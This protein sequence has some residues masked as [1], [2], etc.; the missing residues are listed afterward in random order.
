MRRAIVGLLILLGIIPSLHSQDG[1]FPLCSAEELQHV[2]ALQPELDRLI[3]LLLVE[4]GEVIDVVVGYSTSQIAARS[5]FWARLSPCAEAIETVDLLSN[6]SGDIAAMAALIHA[7]VDSAENPYVV[8]QAGGVKLHDRVLAHFASIAALIE[9]GER[10]AAPAPGER[11][12]PACDGAALEV[13]LDA[14]RDS[15]DII[16]TGSQATTLSLMF[17]YIEAMLD[18]RDGVWDQ[19]M[20]CAD[21][22]HLG[23]LMSATASDIVP[24]YVFRFVGLP[25][26]QNPYYTV[27]Q[28]RLD[29]LDRALEEVFALL[30]GAGELK[31]DAPLETAL[32]ACSA[33]DMAAV[34]VQLAP[35]GALIREA[36]GFDSLQDD[37]LDYISKMIDW[38]DALWSEIPLCAE[39]FEI[40]LLATN[41]ANDFASM[42]ALA[43]AGKGIDITPYHEL[44]VS[45]LSK[46]TDWMVRKRGGGDASQSKAQADSLPHCNDIAREALTANVEQ[47]DIFASMTANIE[48]VDDVLTFGEIQVAWREQ[49]W[50]EFPPCLEAIESGRLLIQLTGDIVPAAALLQF[51]SVQADDIRYLGEISSALE[52]IK[53][54]AAAFD[55]N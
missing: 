22:I 40:S 23:M 9:S 41:A 50:K 15:E 7:G 18:W 54:K 17:E 36:S 53:A 27:L 31:A 38:R 30:V 24:A 46:V 1:G 45:A 8:R 55:E 34:A 48:S 43:L 12:L 42:F 32:P 44:N 14:L 5:D 2:M 33:D 6:T 21:S 37:L 26:E 13:L 16:L 51:A 29:E 19:I 52:R 20:P 4:E 25:V 47:A 10:P 28:E 35:L 11:S 39:A 49:I 3:D